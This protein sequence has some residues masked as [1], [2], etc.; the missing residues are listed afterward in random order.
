MGIKLR[1]FAYICLIPVVNP[2]TSRAIA[3]LRFLDC[4][5]FLA[6]EGRKVDN[7]VR[8]LPRENRVTRPKTLNLIPMGARE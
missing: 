2:Q 3:M 7:C 1:E 8:Y 4:V 6:P 5:N